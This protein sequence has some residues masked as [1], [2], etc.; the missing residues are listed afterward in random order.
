[1]VGM[2]GV[3]LAGASVGVF[4]LSTFDTDIILVK[5]TDLTVA[6]Q[7][8]EAAGHSVTTKSM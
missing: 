2:V 4:V 1:M 8:L 5:G 6:V 3:P 7:P